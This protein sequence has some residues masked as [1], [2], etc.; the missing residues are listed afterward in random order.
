MTLRFIRIWELSNVG[1]SQNHEKD[2]KL[3]L[4]KN[5]AVPEGL[6][7]KDCVFLKS[8]VCLDVE[9]PNDSVFKGK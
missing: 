2:N 5:M 4:T 7:P 9:K 6:N 8:K 3:N 1:R